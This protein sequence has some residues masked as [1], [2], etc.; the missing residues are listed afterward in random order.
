MPDSFFASNKNKKRKRALSSGDAKQGSAKKL[1]RR[2][3]S[4]RDS[5]QHGVKTNGVTQA[6]KRPTDE[7]LDSDRTDDD[8]GGI[9]DLNLRADVEPESSGDE[10][11]EETPAEKR[12]RLAK[13]YL[14][15]VKEGL[16]EGEFDAAEVDKELISARLRQDVLEHSGKAHL[17]V[18][19]SSLSFR[20][21]TRQLYTASYDR[22]LKLYDLSVM[23]YVETLFGHQDTIV[24]LDALRGETVV[25]AGARDR[26]VRYWKIQ[27]ESQLVF[28]GGGRSAVRELL[29]GGAFEG[30]EEEEAEGGKKG[31]EG[32]K[33]FVEGSI[34]CVAM[35]D[36]TNFVSGG[37]TGFVFL[38]TSSPLRTCANDDI[39]R[40]HRSIC[41]WNIQKKK[42]IFTQA[43]CHGFHETH[44]STEGIVQTPRWITAVACLRYSD[45]FASG[46][47]NL[48]SLFFSFVSSFIARD[49]HFWGE[50]DMLMERHDKVLG[51][52]PSEYGNSTPKSNPS[53]SSVHC[54]PQE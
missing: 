28:R 37:D 53:P 43:L 18:A 41:L 36:E 33:K 39:S 34:E 6:K 2:D 45:V 19:D 30:L 12:L 27:E 3:K 14:E 20:K 9:D 11:I 4:S 47:F 22:T 32:K 51:T 13:I 17:F 35:I 5:R 44:S 16:A 25:S 49:L 46:G 48:I 40:P 54:Q 31:K 7:E 21:G 38:V 23:G 10:D 24:A 42:P 26:T 15:N 52:D 1:L 8:E 50:I 29:E